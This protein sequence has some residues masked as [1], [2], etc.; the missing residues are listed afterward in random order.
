MRPWE[1]WTGPVFG[2]HPVLIVSA[3]KRV[4]A[5][6]FVV[7]IKGVTQRPGQPFEVDALQAVL[8]RD[9]GLD[10]DTRF[11]CD[12]FYTLEKKD[13]TQKRGEVRSVERRPD[14]SRKMIQGLAV[15]GL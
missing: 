4:E 15:A 3:Q 10:W 13:I 1:I 12:L 2:P 9:D 11:D 14:I 7:V 8:D 5:K 6:K